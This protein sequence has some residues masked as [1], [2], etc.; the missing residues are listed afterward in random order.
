MGGGILSKLIIKH[1]AYK[2]VGMDLTRVVKLRQHR[3]YD[4]Q[5]GRHNHFTEFLPYLFMFTVDPAM[6]HCLARIDKGYR[7]PPLDHRSLE[8]S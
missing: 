5:T 7:P 2:T 4:D 3:T 1:H 6:S 8:I